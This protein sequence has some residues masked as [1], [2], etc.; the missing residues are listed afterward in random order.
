MDSKNIT[1]ALSPTDAF[2]RRKIRLAYLGIFAVW[3]SALTAISQGMFNSIGTGIV[4]TNFADNPI[5]IIIIAVTLLALIDITGGIW[6][7]IYLCL[8]RRGPREINRMMHVKVSWM[9]LLGAVAAGPFATGCWMSAVNFCGITITTAIMGATPIVTAIVSR[10]VFKER[11]SIRAYLGIVIVVAGIIFA[12]W[13]PPEG[14]NNFYLGVMLALLA[15]IG[16][17]VEGMVCTYAADVV[18]P[19]MGCGIYRT[20]GAGIPGLILVSILSMVTG[21]AGMVTDIIKI[22]FSNGT[23]LMWIVLAGLMGAISY[24]TTYYGFNMCGPARTLAVV[25]TMPVWSI[26]LGLLY[27]GIGITVYSVTSQTILA[28]AIIII[29]LTLVIAKPSELFSLRDL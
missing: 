9:M 26:P 10:I 2:R 27:A 16:F 24:G 18:D 25:N 17:T 11:L 12:A 23:I 5:I 6:S 15:P 20:F 19:I 4:S 8:T 7:F 21:N 28:A 14:M 1:A 13:T 3:I 29:G 22:A